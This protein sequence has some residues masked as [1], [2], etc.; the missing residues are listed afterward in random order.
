MDRRTIRWDQRGGTQNIK[1]NGAGEFVAPIGIGAGIPIKIV[2]DIIDI[3]TT[4]SID[5]TDMSESFKSNSGKI[6]DGPFTFNL[7]IGE[8]VVKETYIGKVKSSTQLIVRRP[9][10]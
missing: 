8:Y 7:P 9:S 2:F 6:Q 3:V 4:I 5:G 10:P 1:G